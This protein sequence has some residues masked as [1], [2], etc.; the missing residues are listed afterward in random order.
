MN[1]L[2]KKL[3]DQS[4][5][6]IIDSAILKNITGGFDPDARDGG[7]NGTSKCCSNGWKETCGTSGGDWCGEFQ[8][9][10]QDLPSPGGM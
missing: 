5:E 1:S 3:S 9:P 2:E 7:G 10:S 4:R 6:E 8:L